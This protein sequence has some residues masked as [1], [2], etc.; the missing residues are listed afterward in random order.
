MSHHPPARIGPGFV[1]AFSGIVALVVGLPAVL[2]ALASRRFGHASPLDGVKA[3][4]HWTADDLQSWGHKL[5]QGL[6][7]SADLVDLFLRAALVAGWVCTAI[8]VYTVVDEVVFQI[9]HGMPSARQ[10]RFG[11]LG[12]IGR[13][14]ATAL[15][16]VLPLSIS[17]TPALIGASWARPVATVIRGLPADVGMP[18]VP[19]PVVPD[20][21][22]GAAS[23]GS[24]IWSLVEVRRGDSVWAIAERVANGRDVAAVAEQI[25]AANLGAE[26]I[27]GRRFTTPALIEPGW[28]LSVPGP[29]SPALP[30]PSADP[31]PST[32]Y[33]VMPGDS[34]WVIAEDHL[35]PSA[36]GSEIVAYT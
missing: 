16:A 35:G 7:S 24:E 11:G 17:S 29:T 8:L 33:V 2:V 5:T 23:E 1:T 34:Y 25:V 13:K 20:E 31:P 12:P 27:D 10:R 22:A 21:A 9:R 15:V 19:A 18:I 28:L 14:L 4:W 30:L 36:S 32:E 26:M 3:P 6:D